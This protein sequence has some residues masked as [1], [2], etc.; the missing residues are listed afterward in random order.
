MRNIKVLLG[1]C[2][3]LLND[4][5]EALVIDACGNSANVKCNRTAW[6]EQ[7][8][9]QG[10]PGTYDLVMLIPSNLRREGNRCT[11]MKS[12]VDVL[13]L[14]RSM[15]ARDGVPVLAFVPAEQRATHESSL[16]EAGADSVL[17]LPF[18]GEVLKSSIRRLL[19]LPAE[20][21]ALTAKHWLCGRTPFCPHSE[22]VFSL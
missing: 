6:L 3:P 5:L 8:E 18:H 11:P 14:V 20:P 7:F 13:A 17:G 19:R 1:N 22:P 12:N 9:H 10:R 21:K 4:Y 16:L 15:K 2:E